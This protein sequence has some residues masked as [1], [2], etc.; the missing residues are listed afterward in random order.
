MRRQEAIV[1]DHSMESFR[2][3]LNRTLTSVVAQMTGR[4][5][6]LH[7]IGQGRQVAQNTN[8]IK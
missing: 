7:R 8:L 5:S 3:K 1:T 2:G 4:T 6:A